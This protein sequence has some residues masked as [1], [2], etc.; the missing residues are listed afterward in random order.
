MLDRIW[1]P[2]TYFWNSKYAFL[3]TLTQQNRLV[4][5]EANGTVLY[6]ARYSHCAP[7]TMFR[8]AIGAQLIRA[9]EVLRVLPALPSRHTNLSFR[10]WQL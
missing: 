1:R 9:C 6:S 7:D 2:D 3:H 4:R 10:D 8:H 5:L